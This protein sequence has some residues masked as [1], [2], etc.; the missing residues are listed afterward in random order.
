[1][2]G[3]YRTVNCTACDREALTCE[4]CGGSHRI[5]ER[6]PNPT[7]IKLSFWLVMIIL[8]AV[9]LKLVTKP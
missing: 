8:A 3:N 6:I 9:L 7:R 2:I 4:L 5:A 1:M